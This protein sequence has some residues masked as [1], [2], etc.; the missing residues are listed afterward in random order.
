MGQ[1]SKTRDY[2][3]QIGLKFRYWWQHTN[4]P[5]EEP[6]FVSENAEYYNRISITAAKQFRLDARRHQFWKAQGYA[7]DATTLEVPY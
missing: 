3:I 7:Q 4:N 2:I 5:A 1:H 6:E